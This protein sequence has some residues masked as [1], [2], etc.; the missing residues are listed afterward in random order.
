M[1]ALAIPEGIRNNSLT[2][3]AGRLRAHGLQPV[4]ILGALRETNQARCIPPLP[5]AELRNIARSA[6]KWKSFDTQRGGEWCAANIL[7]GCFDPRLTVCK[8]D[9]AAVVEADTSLRLK[10]RHKLLYRMLVQFYGRFGC[11]P[12]QSTLATALITSRQQIARNIGRLVQVGLI[13]RETGAWRRAG[14]KFH[15]DAYHFRKHPLFRAHFGASIP[16]GFKELRESTQQFSDVSDAPGAPALRN[17]RDTG[18]HATRGTQ[19]TYLDTR[20]PKR[21]R[22]EIPPFDFE[23]AGTFK[24]CVGPDKGRIIHY[25]AIAQYIECAAGCGGGRIIYA[26]GTV[27]SYECSCGNVEAAA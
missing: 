24:A 5:D 20:L 26:D 1:S 12:A 27:K 7:R 16:S 4:E 23:T 19:I 18:I 10:R 2:S 6:A 3:F 14:G 15:C 11:D 25:S 8:F 22:A 13:V 21:S 17:Q 9:A